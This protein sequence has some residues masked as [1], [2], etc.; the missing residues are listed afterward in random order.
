VRR[1][2]LAVGLVLL[3][4]SALWRPVAIPQLVRFPSHVDESTHYAGTF[5]LFVDQATGQVLA[6]PITLPLEIDRRVRTLP[7]SGAHTAV[8]EEAVSY[9]IAD[10][11]QQERH[12]YVIDRRSMQ[13]RDDGRSWS[14]SPG[15]R[16]DDAGSYRVT[17]PMGTTAD[18][19]YRI[20]ENEPGRSFW[21][22]GDPD[23]ARVRQNGLALIGFQ[24]VWHGVPVAPYYREELRK[25]GLAVELTL[26]LLGARLAADGVDVESALDAL[27]PADASIVAAARQ[28]RL[29][30]RF[31]R[32]N[33]GHALVE[34]R[35][36][37]IIDLVYS[38]EAIT[39]TVDLAPLRELRTALGRQPASPEA[40]ALAGALDAVER[41]A[42]T[43]VYSLRYEE[44][45]ASVAD[46][47]QRTKND[48]R[49]L[50]LVERYVP[51][52][53][54]ALS[55]VLLAVVAVD[56]W[57]RRRTETAGRGT[58]TPDE[59]DDSRSGPTPGPI[60]PR[61]GRVSS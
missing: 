5:T 32:D 9:R 45:A 38:E 29:P 52:G 18:D 49:K 50:D 46:A 54:V 4:A 30:L 42:P 11:V 41:A 27:P 53:L 37:A 58:P 44:T 60:H 3:V 20:W 12:H 56:R 17:L 15:N 59:R 51:G 14:F 23:R 47:A 22:V 33:D 48:L 34:P 1:V 40:T 36:G 7:G 24:E 16:I 19:R 10:M 2:L 6:D 35:T 57:R 8:V 39:A 26:P 21:M 55:F 28:T 13:H 43:P 61:P 31:F 25:Q